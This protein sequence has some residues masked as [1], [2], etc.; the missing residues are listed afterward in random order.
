M[1][2]ARPCCSLPNCWTAA[3]SCC[4]Q[5]AASSSEPSAAKATQP[6][7]APTRPQAS[8]P[9]PAA[10]AALAPAAEPQAPGFQPAPAPAG[11]LA[12]PAAAAP[13][14][15]SPK[16]RGALAA[17]PAAAAAAQPAVRP[18]QLRGRRAVLLHL[19]GAA[20]HV[21]RPGGWLCLLL[22]VS[23]RGAGGLICRGPWPGWHPRRTRQGGGGGGV[24]W[25]RLAAYWG[26]HIG[27]PV[28]GLTPAAAAAGS[29]LCPAAPLS[30]VQ[31]CGTQPVLLQ[32]LPAGPAV[33]RQQQVV[34]LAM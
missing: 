15:A 23:L 31:V 28:V 27:V 29:T 11:R 10:S 5:P 12:A 7:P 34:R 1:P 25:R 24:G 16:T 14:A 19:E 30:A 32:G 33:Q 20:G 13:V 9:P 6:A 4:R 2:L 21:C 3:P 26:M 22:L 18:A 17:A 8:Q